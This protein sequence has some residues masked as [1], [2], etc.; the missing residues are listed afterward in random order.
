MHSFYR[1]IQNTSGLNFHAKKDEFIK[2]LIP[3]IGKESSFERRLEMAQELNEHYPDIVAGGILSLFTDEELIKH[4]DTAMNL[5]RTGFEGCTNTK[6][7]SYLEKVEMYLKDL[8][9]RQDP[10]NSKH[11]KDSPG[12]RCLGAI[13]HDDG[14][15]EWVF[16]LNDEYTYNFERPN[17][18]IIRGAISDNHEKRYKEDFPAVSQLNFENS[19]VNLQILGFRD[20]RGDSGNFVTF[21]DPN[22]FI[23]HKDKTLQLLPDQISRDR[24]SV[25]NV[26]VLNGIV[27]PDEF[28]EMVK[29]HHVVVSNKEGFDHDAAIHLFPTI[30]VILNSET[31]HFCNIMEKAV[32]NYTKYENFI[33]NK[34]RANNNR[35]NEWKLNALLLA[36]RFY[37]D[38]ITA[39]DD[40]GER[41]EINDETMIGYFTFTL[42]LDSFWIAYKKE[43]GELEN[44]PDVEQIYKTLR[45]RKKSPDVEQI[46]E[47]LKELENNS[48]VQI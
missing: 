19:N 42:N 16:R 17:S 11:E 34:M 26:G 7:K 29:K 44:S 40:I 38:F 4:H 3:V 32:D 13:S 47:L 28:N 22:N 18:T 9:Y 8:T 35:E 24:L 6:Q 2:Q 30:D 5:F 10:K 43:Y 21:P 15:L 14:R 1:N 25:L 23:E 46:I 37:L 27:S 20:E 33:L 41:E 12:Y 39:Y 48:S 31:D 36:S 45:K